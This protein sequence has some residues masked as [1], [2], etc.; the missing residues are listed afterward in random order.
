MVSLLS[1]QI[2]L[3]SPTPDAGTWGMQKHAQETKGLGRAGP[4]SMPSPP[5]PASP[6]IVSKLSSYL[7]STVSRG[8]TAKARGVE[9]HA[10]PEIG[11]SVLTNKLVPQ[12]LD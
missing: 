3:G 5:Y 2:A 12:P 11:S 8:C 1:Y 7:R 4:A 9:D 6:Q 10:K